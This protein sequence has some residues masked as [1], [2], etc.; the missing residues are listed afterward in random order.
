MNDAPSTAAPTQET[1]LI[2][3]DQPENIDVLRGI[4]KRH[5]R[6]Q[7]ATNGEDALSIAGSGLRPDLILMDI[8]MPGMDGYEV[9]RRLKSDPVTQAIPVIFVT[10]LY[11]SEDESR[12]FEAGAVDYLIKPLSPL[13]V[14]ARVR[15]HLALSNQKRHL[16]HLV[17]ERTK[18]L[19]RT[20]AQIIRRLSRA[21]DFK[22]DDTGNQVWGWSHS[23][24]LLGLAGGLPRETAEVIF[25]AAPMHDIGK[26]G[27]P[28]A[29][30]R[31]TGKLDEAEWA[32]MRKHPKIGA[33]I[34]GRHDD[35]LLATARVVALTH[36][37]KWDGSGYPSGLAG[38]EIPLSGRIV[39]LCDVFDALTSDRP[40]KK[41]WP[42][43]EAMQYI[44]DQSGK[45]FDPTLVRHFLAII[46]QLLTVR[47][48]YS[49]DRGEVTIEC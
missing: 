19:T 16:E 6:L 10:A 31:K 48:Q 46:P 4:L 39:A 20:R 11:S 29:I 2:C 5:Y 47:D 28:D 37:E 38:E 49:D 8:S 3:D 26:I 30:L 17:Q 13:V 40:Y 1:L 34:I 22:D 35:P 43:T 14:A 9:C 25:T 36:H 32:E 42:V 7:I 27:V 12:G 23:G 15:T 33:G 45:H 21:A 44:K 41:A 24:G 18:E